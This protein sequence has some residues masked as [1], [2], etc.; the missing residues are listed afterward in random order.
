MNPGEP[1]RPRAAKQPVEDRLRLVVQR[2]RRRNRI[3]QPLRENL[4]KPAVAQMPGRFFQGLLLRGCGGGRIHAMHVKGKPE[5]LRQRGNELFVPIGFRSANA[6]MH[7][8]DGK[9]QADFA[10]AAGERAQQTHGVRARR[11]G[12]GN[13][14]AGAQRRSVEGGRN[15]HRSI[16]ERAAANENRSRAAAECRD[17]AGRLILL[18]MLKTRTATVS[19]AALITH[20]R[21][22]MFI[23]AGRNDGPVLDVMCEAHEPWV[24]RE[25]T[26]S[27]YLGWIGEDDGKPVAGAGLLLLNW[28]PH[29]LDP[30]STQR[31]YLL[32]VY[33][34]PEYRR[35]KLASNLIELA[36]AEARK[37]FIRVVALHS[38]EEGRRLYEAN[39]FRRTN[40]MFY[41]E[42]VE[43]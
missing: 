7:V 31:G 19:D 33:V 42:P 38:T 26:E 6:V 13:S 39:G 22:R 24:A 20:H 12:D 21:R 29:P 8:G 27:R 41:V 25:I 23:D 34:D 5:L 9:H 2:V 4:P 1:F 11:H 32:N 30:R 15:A 28:P 3:S 40:E 35:R 14:H 16:V 43:G 10:R 18:F 36:L 17:N 37:R